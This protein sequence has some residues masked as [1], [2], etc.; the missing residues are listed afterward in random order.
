MYYHADGMTFNAPK[1]CYNSSFQAEEGRAAPGEKPGS[2]QKWVSNYVPYG[3][4]PAGKA[5]SAATEDETAAAAKDASTSNG[6]D[7]KWTKN[8]VPFKEGDADEKAKE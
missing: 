2:Q 6:V 8:Y 3:D 5:S 1:K 7:P 4:F